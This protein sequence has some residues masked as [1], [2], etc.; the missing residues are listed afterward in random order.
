MNVSETWLNPN[1]VG[2]VEPIQPA[3]C[4]KPRI[5][6][7]KWNFLE[8]YNELGKVKIFETLSTIFDGE[9]DL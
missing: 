8:V 3:P 6:V 7:K 9:M 4:R 5:T 2:G 1:E